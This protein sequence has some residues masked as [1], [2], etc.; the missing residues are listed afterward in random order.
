MKK[1]FLI[2][3]GYGNIKIKEFFFS[4]NITS[5][6]TSTIEKIH[7]VVNLFEDYEIIGKYKLLILKISLIILNIILVMIIFSI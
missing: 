4:M 1:I 2:F 5:Q 3:E 6:S 7:F